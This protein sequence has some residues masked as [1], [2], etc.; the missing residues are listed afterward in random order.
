MNNI[1]SIHDTNR[2]N[3]EYNQPHTLLLIQVT[4]YF[5]GGILFMALVISFPTLLSLYPPVC[6]R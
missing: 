6:I 1:T 5:G 4:H 3:Q 2:T